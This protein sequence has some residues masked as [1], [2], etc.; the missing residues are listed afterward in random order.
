MNFN[1]HSSLKDAHAF[2]SPSNYHWLNYDEDKLEAVYRNSQAKEEG[3]VLHAFASLAIIK[4]IKLANNKKALNMF[5]NDAIGYKMESEQVL[6]YSDNIFGTA[7]AILFKDN[8]LRIHDLKTGISKPSFKQLFIYAALF[9]L[10]YGINPEDIEIETRLYQ[11]N[12]FTV[13]VPDPLYIREIMTKIV[14]FDIVLENLKK[15]K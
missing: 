5:V 4:R 6:Y 7:D 15:L 12:N 2:L 11:G 14:Q 10:E 3:T 1:D 8:L 13:E 9:C